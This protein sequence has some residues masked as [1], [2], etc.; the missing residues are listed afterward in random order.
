MANLRGIDTHAHVFSATAAAVA[1]ARYRPA[2]AATLEGWRAHWAAAGITH[3][4][5]V[6]PSFFGSDNSEM[7]AAL[8][9][10]PARLRGVAVVD[11][12]V[13]QAMLEHM[14][15]AGVRALRLNL[16]GAAE[17]EHLAGASWRSLFERT[18]G[19]GWHVEVFVDTGC[20][21]AIARV[22]ADSPISVVF[23]HFGAPG[24]DARSADATFAAAKHLAASRP[25]W[26]KLSAPYRLE[27][28]DPNALAARWIETVG[29]NRLVWGSD[30]PWTRHEKSADYWRL[31][32]TLERWVGEERA[33]AILWDNAA[34]LYQFD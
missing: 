33:R 5:L 12:R 14:Q 27:G 19:L 28:G 15:A 23:D 7:L 21:P 10:E 26:C 3:G 20:V 30:W 18:H 29:A 25:V 9:T 4:V 8:A 1:G 11:D 2:Y 13:D 17:F 34:R 24:P 32:D 16:H 22:L 6:Q 31:R